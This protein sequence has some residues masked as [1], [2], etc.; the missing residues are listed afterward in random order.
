MGACHKSNH[1]EHL[2]RD[3]TQSILAGEEVGGLSCHV[4]Y[5]RQLIVTSQ[6]YTGTQI[7]NG[8]L[9]YCQ[10]CSGLDDCPP[11]CW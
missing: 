5:R 4:C 1:K 11:Q 2:T 3:V 10:E 9:C 7:A 8:T 6:E